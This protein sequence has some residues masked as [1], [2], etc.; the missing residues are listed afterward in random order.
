MDASTEVL[1]DNNVTLA[2]TMVEQMSRDM[3]LGLDNEILNG[4]GGTFEGLRYTGS[5][6]NSYSAGS[7]TGAGNISVTAISKAMDQVLTDNHEAPNVGYFH[8]RTIGSLRILTDSSARPLLNN[9]TWGSPILKE[10]AVGTIYGAKIKAA[11]QLPINLSY[12]TAS[13]A[14][15]DAILGVS[16]QFGYYGNRRGIKFKTDY[17]INTDVNQYQATMRAAFSIKY[18][19]AYSVI[20]AINN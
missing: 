10:G 17:N 5:Y 7:G 2:N 20:K 12:S 4:T 8:T 19:N 16:K 14:A 6:T 13:T 18:A 3:A 15:T 11:N 1:E 9:E